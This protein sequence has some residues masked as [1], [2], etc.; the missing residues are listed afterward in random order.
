MYKTGLKPDEMIPKTTKLAPSGSFFLRF[1]WNGCIESI[2]AKE[3]IL[4]V[5]EDDRQR[6]DEIAN[7]LRTSIVANECGRVKRLKACQVVA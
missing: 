7:R 3:D 2:V 4:E 5:I 6:E 1:T